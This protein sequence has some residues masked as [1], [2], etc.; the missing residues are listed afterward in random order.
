MNPPMELFQILFR[1]RVRSL[2]VRHWIKTFI[3]W[4]KNKIIF[5][6]L[7]FFLTWLQ[8]S[9]QIPGKNTVIWNRAETVSRP[10][11]WPDRV[12]FDC[13]AFRGLI[14]AGS[15]FQPQ[16]LHHFVQF[17]FRNFVQNWPKTPNKGSGLLYKIWAS[18]WFFKWQTFD[19]GRNFA[20]IRVFCPLLKTV[21]F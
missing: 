3:F 12:P 17:C 6:K 21:V 11:W 20:S 5:S 14:Y 19:T 10:V 4:K 2:T 7:F 18:K 9:A 15:Y 13:L 8:I 16:F 1:I